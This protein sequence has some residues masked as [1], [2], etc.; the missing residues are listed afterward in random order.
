M[1]VH[2]MIAKYCGTFF[3]FFFLDEMNVFLVSD[4][5]HGQ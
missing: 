5:R 2:Q 1:L 4:L 3:F